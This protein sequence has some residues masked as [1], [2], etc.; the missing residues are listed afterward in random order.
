[1]ANY[2]KPWSIA[3]F[4]CTGLTLA[5][6]RASKWSWLWL[7]LLGCTVSTYAVICSYWLYLAFPREKATL[8][9]VGAGTLALFLTPQLWLHPGK[10]WALA[11]IA[12]HEDHWAALRHG[13][14]ENFAQLPGILLIPALIRSLWIPGRR[15]VLMWKMFAPTFLMVAFLLGAYSYRFV[16]LYPLMLMIVCEAK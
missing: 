7:A 12:G 10:S 5:I 2:I 6:L 11:S 15:E 14:W 3:A 8:Y 4:F 16:P 13:I 9:L 1:M